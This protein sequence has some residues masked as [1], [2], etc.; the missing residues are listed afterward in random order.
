M[1][2]S[3]SKQNPRLVQKTLASGK[4]S[5]S[6]EYYIGRE[7]TPKLDEAGEP[8]YY[9]SGKMAGEPMYEI[10]HER[11]KEA[12]NL[13]LIAKPRTPEDRQQNKDTLL[14]A[15]NIRHQKE[16]AFLQD[17]KGYSL[18]INRQTDFITCFQE[19]L[20]DYTKKDKRNV[21]Q[22]LHR[23]EAYLQDCHPSMVHK[24]TRDGKE[25]C[26]YSLS[27]K[28]L[29]K[30]LIEG[31]IEYL[32]EHSAG[33]GA[34]TTYK[35][36][37]KVCKYAYEQKWINSN[38]CEGLTIKKEKDTLS[39]DVLTADEITRLLGTH[40]TGENTEI[41]RAFIFSLF[42]GIRFCDVKE[43]EYQNIKPNKKGTMC[44]IF[45]QL[46]T[47]NIAEIPL[48][49]DILQ[50]ISRPEGAAD[51][52]KLFVLPSHTMCL[53]ALRHWIARAGIDKHIT[54]HCA[55]HSF[56]TNL[57]TNGANIK[58]VAELLGH[59]GLSQVNVYVKALEE[60]KQEAVNSLPSLNIKP[61][62]V[63]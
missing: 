12:L 59:S 29:N 23:F 4:V 6:L 36:F 55:R 34:L 48:R 28:G 7:Y 18:T 56:A 19:Y 63:Q 62:M 26:T 53:K 20:N 10:H 13:Y 61:Q 11:K 54:W 35:R 39:K 31:F 37:K 5:L 1:A 24:F 50:M 17:R 51:D 40:Y 30:K 58:V 15:E 42:T 22:S 16:Q 60:Q 47:G 25:I 32:K 21:R 27:A 43:L 33:S 46:K 44:A 52:A 14:L 3:A 57:L 49:E 8:M 2:Q 38:P 9:T 45:T 41:Q